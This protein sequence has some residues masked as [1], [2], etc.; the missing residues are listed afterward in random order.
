M[1][2]LW[3]TKHDGP[4]VLEVREA[5]DPHPATGEVR[6]RVEA[7]GLNFSDVLARI[8]FYPAA[9]KPPCVLG[10]EVSGIV[11]HTGAGAEGFA[12]GDRV[13]AMT[14]FGG[15]A[16]TVCVSAGSAIK[17][18]DE[19]S[20]ETA[21]ALP[22]NYLTAGHMA[23][24]VAGVRPGDTVLV[25]A[26][27][28][29]VGQALL[30]FCQI[31]GGVRVLGTAS[32]SK[33]DILRRNGCAE[34]IDYR[35]KDYVAEVRRLTGNEGVDVVFDCLGGADWKRGY[36]LLRSGGRLVAYGFANIQSGGA[37]RLLP[38]L[39]QLARMPR[40][41][42]LKLMTDNKSVSGVTLSHM[43]GEPLLPDLTEAVRLCREGKLRPHVDS[44]F[45][46]ARA[47]DAH[48]RLETRQSSGKVILTP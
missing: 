30:Q 1:R 15:H 12:P 24:R 26:A 34:A 13:V 32:A 20:F 14:K 2:A 29:G 38:A 41:T 22:V 43:W 5:P 18:P 31:I 44:T 46:F 23:R 3:M 35:T 9:P 10:Y 25:H 27:A 36:S 16:D 37:R 45:S 42:P 48:R 28:G 47:A 7:A 17:L 21:A 4:Q 19:V 40:F 8:G 11:D 33:H 39:A 6:I